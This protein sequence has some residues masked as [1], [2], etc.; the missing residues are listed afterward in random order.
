MYYDVWRF[1]ARCVDM[2][3]VLEEFLGWVLYFPVDDLVC[4]SRFCYGFSSFGVTGPIKH[5]LD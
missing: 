5:P 4:Y 3:T 2:N 1:D